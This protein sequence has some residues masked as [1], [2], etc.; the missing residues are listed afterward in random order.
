MWPGTWKP[1]GRAAAGTDLP[2]WQVWELAGARTCRVWHGFAVGL[3]G[4]VP[5]ALAFGPS[6]R[7]D[8]VLASA[9]VI[10]AVLGLACGFPGGTYP[11]KVIWR[12]HR[13]GGFRRRVMT[14]LTT[15]LTTGFAIG[16]ATGIAASFVRLPALAIGVVVGIPTGIAAGI[17]TGLRAYAA[18]ALDERR[19]IRELADSASAGPTDLT[20]FS[21]ADTALPMII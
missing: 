7:L 13:R 6:L 16:M 1:N 10:G 21:A 4:G 15:G 18:P 19:I 5:A 2:V 11:R 3:V 14:G 20:H 9:P 17:T 12:T 8:V